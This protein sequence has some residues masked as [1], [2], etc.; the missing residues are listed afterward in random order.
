MLNTSA[1]D[2]SGLSS[3]M[4]K[5]KNV[6]TKEDPWFIAKEVC[7]LLQIK[8]I[9]VLMNSVEDNHWEFYIIEQRQGTDVVCII[10]SQTGL[11]NLMSVSKIP[12]AIEY[13]MWKNERALRD[14]DFNGM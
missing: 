7:E 5:L 12:E 6:G 13:Q 10:I 3:V 2:I 9:S 8:D 4:S 14:L 11:L 1:K